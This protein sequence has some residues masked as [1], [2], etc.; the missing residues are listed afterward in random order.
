MSAE[1][2]SSARPEADP[3]TVAWYPP[4]LTMIYAA[5][6]YPFQHGRRAIHVLLVDRSPRTARVRVGVSSV[7][8]PEWPFFTPLAL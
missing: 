5:S 2:I 8:G 7:V 6:N 3:A 1:K 4:S